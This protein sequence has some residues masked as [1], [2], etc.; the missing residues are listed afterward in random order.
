MIHG[1]GVDALLTKLNSTISKIIVSKV[2]DRAAEHEKHEFAVHVLRECS[3][4]GDVSLKLSV[5]LAQRFGALL[6][7]LVKFVL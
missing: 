6:L 4:R 5:V 1:D 7:A 2:L 3:R